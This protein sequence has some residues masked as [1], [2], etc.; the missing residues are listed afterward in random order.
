MNDNENQE[1]REERTEAIIRALS[2]VPTAD[3]RRTAQRFGVELDVSIG[4]EHNF[5]AGLVE[6]MSVGGVFI[7]THNLKPIG[8]V[9]DLA[10]TLPDSDTTL[11]VRGEVRWL[12]DY[13]ESSNVSPGMG[14]RFLEL[15][16]DSQA[17]IAV[18][19]S[20]RDPLFFDE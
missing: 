6:N 13:N 9:I 10:I 3:N 8:T 1:S 15:G 5:Y 14:V 17:A 2:M 12:R 16:P 19:L 4:S 7:A 20:S 18:F 11:N